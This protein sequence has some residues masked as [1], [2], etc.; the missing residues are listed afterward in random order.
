MWES[1]NFGVEVPSTPYGPDKVPPAARLVEGL[2][3]L[4]NVGI[5]PVVRVAGRDWLPSVVVP[6]GPYLVFNVVF[7]VFC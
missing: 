2:Y 5:E 7:E 6:G 3:C 1:P 4:G